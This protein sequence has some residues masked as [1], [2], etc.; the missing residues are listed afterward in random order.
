ME[1]REQEIL[2]KIEEKTKDVKVPESLMPEKIEMLL[3]DK[4]ERYHT[5]QS[6][7]YRRSAG[8]LSS[9]GCR[10]WDRRKCRQRS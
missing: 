3:E 1:K 8:G 6:I 9:T 7:S 2:E 5:Y 10:N 4:G